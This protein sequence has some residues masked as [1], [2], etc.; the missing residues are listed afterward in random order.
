MIKEEKDVTVDDAT[1]D[2]IAERVEVIDALFTFAASS[3]EDERK[4]RVRA[5][6]ALVALGRI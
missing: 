3:F 2:L 4:R 1:W 6:N 5:I